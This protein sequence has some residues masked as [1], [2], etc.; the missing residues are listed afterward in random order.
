MNNQTGS[1]DRYPLGYSDDEAHRLAVQAAYF[2]DLTADVLRRAGL[3]PGMRVLD[4]G[5]GIGDV[6]ML[7]GAMVGAEGSVLGLDRNR[8]SVET[9]RRRAE[10][11][12]ISN[13]RFETAELDTFEST[14]VF[15]AVIGRLVLLYQ[16]DPSAILRRFA[17][18]LRPGGI[19]AFQEIDIDMSCEPPSALLDRVRHW[20][21]ATLEAGGADPRMGRKLLHAFLKAELPRPTM[22]ASSRVE[23]GPNSVVYRHHADIL[24]SLLPLAERLGIVKATEVAIDT[25]AYRLRQTAIESEQVTFESRLVGAWSRLTA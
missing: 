20:I 16:S 10:A 1:P 22:I 24:R 7:A 18:T 11:L 9:A 12:H 2:E 15:D 5:C 19:I 6:S 8:S 14:E 23:S 21:V 17:K 25:M 13:L 4:L 3:T